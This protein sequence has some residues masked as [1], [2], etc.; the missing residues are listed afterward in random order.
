MRDVGEEEDSG[1]VAQALPFDSHH[2]PSR[3][4]GQ[5]PPHDAPVYVKVDQRVP[6]LVRNVVHS[7][8][9]MRMCLTIAADDNAERGGAVKIA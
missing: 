1:G 6:D 5:R 3:D 8:E 2:I 7:V 9:A 4:P